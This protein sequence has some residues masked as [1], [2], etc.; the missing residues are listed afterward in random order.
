VTAEQG[1]GRLNVAPAL[2]PDGKAL[3]FLSERDQYSIDV[4][5]ADAATGA[6]TRKLIETAVD[7]HFES[8]QFIESA[9]AW[10]LAGRRFAL[11]AVSR[12]RPIVT[13]LDM[14]TG[15]VE[16]ELALGQ[17]DQI[18]S[19]TWSPDGRRLAFSALKGGLSDLYMVDLETGALRGLTKDPFADLQP[20]WSPDGKTI[21]FAT[22]RFSSSMETLSFGNYRLGTID[23]ESGAIRELPGL[24][25]AKNIDPHWSRDGASLYFIADADDVSNVYRMVTETGELFQVTDVSTG[26]TGVTALSPALSVAGAT[27]RLAFSVYRHGAYEIHSIDASAGTPIRPPTSTAPLVA[28]AFSAPT[29]GLVDG[30]AFAVKPYRHGL[31]LDGVAQ[32]YLNAD[33]GGTGSYLRAGVSLS[34]G[35]MLSDQRLQTALQVGKSADDFA[36]QAAY[37]NLQARWNWAIVGGQIP[38]FT[39]SSESTASVA[40]GDG[41]TTIARRSEQ[42]RQLHRQISGM[43]IYPFSGARRLELTAGA[44]AIAFDRKTTTSMYSGLTGR[45]LNESHSTTTAAQPAALVETGA[46]LVYD[47]AIFGPTSPVLGQR[48]RFAAAPTIGTLTFTTVTADYR[49][50]IMPVRPFTVA[51]RLMHIGRYGSDADDPRLLPLV[52]TLRD[53][54]RGYGDANSSASADYLGVARLL[55]GNAEV[56]FPLLSAF[57]QPQRRSLPLEGLVFSDL[58]AFRMPAPLGSNGPTW[59]ALASTG[60]GVRLNAA[61]LIFEFDAARRVGQPAATS[62]W[63]FAFNFR[64]GF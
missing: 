21:A 3:V 40:D 20:A 37:V 49:K 16:R 30:R 18:F 48:Y 31:S 47:T 59:N 54:V 33:G 15:A 52:W 64:P 55:V 44:H 57:A 34:F 7:P 46:A 28:R 13:I 11:A 42:F 32:P 43:A 25:G 24:A 26:V 1:G 35:D 8:L 45:L 17:L 29:F 10:D 39:N 56:R 36:A 60:A 6:I 22:D 53:I 5:L 58:G 50:Y 62:G 4:F 61:G 12:G 14:R 2:S 51:T 9:G 23:V 63:T 41:A 19:P 27:N 38:W